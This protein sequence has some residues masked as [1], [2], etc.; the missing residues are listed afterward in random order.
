VL[1][2][3]LSEFD[4][5]SYASPLLDGEGCVAGARVLRNVAVQHYERRR[6]NNS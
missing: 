3:L 6:L 4:A 1:L 5:S 2:I